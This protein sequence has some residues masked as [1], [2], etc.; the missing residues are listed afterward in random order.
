MIAQ[1]AQ[2][3]DF[4]LLDQNGKT[5]TL[6][7]MKGRKFVVYVY[8]KDDTPGCT[9][10]GKGFTAAKQKYD[11]A[12]ITVF[13]L[14]ADDVASHRSF[15]D[16]FAFSHLLLADP[17]EK[18]LTALGVEKSEWKGHVF[19]KRT[20]FLVDAAGKVAKIYENV[21]PQNHEE[22]ILKDFVNF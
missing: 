18:L 16:K 4:S 11:A 17:E 19:W 21:D 15:C 14:S 7:G 13:G 1:G 10:Q 3:P 6:A 9:L 20:T 12:G 22:I 8:P 5:H 2:F